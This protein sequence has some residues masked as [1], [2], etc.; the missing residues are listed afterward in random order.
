MFKTRAQMI[1]DLCAT[2]C[3][4]CGRMADGTFCD[5]ICANNWDREH[6]E[7]EQ[8]EQDEADATAHSADPKEP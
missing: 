5:D 7:A 3:K 2:P 4:Q 1:E 8:A 6:D